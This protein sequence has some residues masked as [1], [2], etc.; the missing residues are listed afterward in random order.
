MIGGAVFCF[1]ESVFCEQ[2]NKKNPDKINMKFFSTSLFIQIPC[3]TNNINCRPQ[4]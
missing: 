2:A 4:I 3:S 1:E